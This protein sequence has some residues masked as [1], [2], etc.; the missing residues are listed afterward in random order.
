MDDLVS[1]ARAELRQ[2]LGAIPA[3]DLP[4]YGFRDEGELASA[5]VGRPLPVHVLSI[6]PEDGPSGSI[7]PSSVHYV[8]PIMI[9][10]QPRAFLR[11]RAA[12]GRFRIVAIG[13][14][15]S[16]RQWGLA[17]TKWT[18]PEYH[19]SFARYRDGVADFIQIEHRDEG[20][21]V[22]LDSG[23][24]ALGLAPRFSPEM[25]LRQLPPRSVLVARL[26]GSLRAEGTR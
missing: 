22:P 11:A 3:R 2:W 26:R 1:V 7:V 9:G 25:S 18:S 23:E 13:D 10:D 21:L 8:L 24:R 14:A 20:F 15:T 5:T 16:A 17:T 19:L 6:E 12:G 4:E